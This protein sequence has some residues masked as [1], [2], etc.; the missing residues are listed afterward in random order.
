VKWGVPFPKVPVYCVV[1]KKRQEEPNMRRLG[2]L[3]M[4]ILLIT[5]CNAMQPNMEETKLL[6]RETEKNMQAWALPTKTEA[7]PAEKL[8]IIPEPTVEIPQKTPTPTEEPASQPPT[9]TPIPDQDKTVQES[10]GYH[11]QTTPQQE[12]KPEIIDWPYITCPPEPS[13]TPEIDLPYITAPE[14]PTYTGT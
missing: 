14:V 2:T 13:S 10:T 1:A 3:V 9:P 4:V 7:S 5:G 8:Q 6:W 11:E 12:E